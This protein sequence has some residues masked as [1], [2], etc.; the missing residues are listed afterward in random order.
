MANLTVPE[1]GNVYDLGNKEFQSLFDNIEF[2][3]IRSI[4]LSGNSYG[5]DACIWLARNIIR[6]CRNLQIVDFSNM[7]D[8]RP[9]E[10]I[11][12]C[13]FILMN[14]IKD[15]KVLELNLSDNDLGSS[16]EA[17]QDVIDSCH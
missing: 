8:G 11:N 10:E 2:L 4:K 14:S 3:C 1:E 6:K 13:M 5:I 17:V 15:F 12:K 7:F 16:M 9:R